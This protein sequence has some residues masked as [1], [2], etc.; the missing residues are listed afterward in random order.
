MAE[1]KPCPFCGSE[2]VAYIEEEHRVFGLIGAVHCRRCSARGAFTLLSKGKSETEA[3]EAWDRRTANTPCDLCRFNP[4]S[5][6]DGKPCTMCVAEGR[7]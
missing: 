6:G 4:P 7:A 3:I 1:L 5:S 2:S